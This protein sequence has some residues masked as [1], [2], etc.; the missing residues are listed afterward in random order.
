MLKIVDKC[1]KMAM[2]L[3]EVVKYMIIY[4]SVVLS[5]DY[6]KGLPLWKIKSEWK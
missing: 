4:L 6:G 1:I 2:N 5:L 3:T